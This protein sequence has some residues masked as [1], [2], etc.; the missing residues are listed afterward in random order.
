M[1]RKK[2]L[3]LLIIILICSVF[4]MYSTPD[5][6]LLDEARTLEQNQRRIGGTFGLSLLITTSIFNISQPLRS[7]SITPLFYKEHLVKYST[8]II[9]SFSFSFLDILG[10]KN[11]LEFSYSINITTPSVHKQD[12]YGPNFFVDFGLK[13]GLISKDKIGIAYK[14]SWALGYNAYPGF[15]L[16]I[17]NS[18]L[19]G[20]NNSKINFNFVPFLQDSLIIGISPA[21]VMYDFALNSSPIITIVPGAELNWNMN[22]IGNFIF[23]V[24]LV[25][26]YEFNFELHYAN[27][28]QGNFVMGI[29]FAWM[30]KKTKQNKL[31]D[32]FD[33]L[34]EE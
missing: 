28:I 18:L 1:K 3:M 22:L 26:K 23:I 34:E 31:D 6:G 24:G 32:M 4:S 7:F 15:D 10:L 2:C 14:F 21:S 19:I 20:T 8:L 29:H 13:K 12:I 25:G 16:A 9:P 27:F 11:N 17:K 33:E 5:M 30:G